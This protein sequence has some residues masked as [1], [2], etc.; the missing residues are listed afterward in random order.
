MM[1]HKIFKSHISPMQVKA[2]LVRKLKPLVGKGEGQLS[3]YYFEV[4]VYA[5]DVIG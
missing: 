5:N 2:D 4:K 3:A 1:F